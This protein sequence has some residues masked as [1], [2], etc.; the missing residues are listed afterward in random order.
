VGLTA[1]QARQTSDHATEQAGRK[2]VIPWMLRAAMQ[3]LGMV[4][5]EAPKRIP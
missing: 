4:K 1:D 5:P 3:E 2:K